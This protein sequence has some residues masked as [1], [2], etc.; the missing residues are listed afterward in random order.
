MYESNKKRLKGFSNKKYFVYYLF[1]QRK[2]VRENVILK[3]ASM[4]TKHTYT[5]KMATPGLYYYW[6][7]SCLLYTG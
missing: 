1:I 2:K 7:L 5:K 6:V 3:D 4:Y